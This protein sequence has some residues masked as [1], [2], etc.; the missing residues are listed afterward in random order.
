MTEMMM[1]MHH[2]S[3]NFAFQEVFYCVGVY[4]FKTVFYTAYNPCFYIPVQS[5]DCF[6]TS[7]VQCETVSLT[8]PVQN[9]TV[10]L[11]SPV[12]DETVS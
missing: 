2:F 7:P 11:T 1:F 9:E 6:C 8:S 3:I 5:E 10:S 4:I 12:K